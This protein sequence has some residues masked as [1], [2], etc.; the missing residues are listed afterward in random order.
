MHLNNLISHKI[1]EHRLF[2]QCGRIDMSLKTI[3]LCIQ[4]I[5][6]TNVIV[7]QTWC[8]KTT[9]QSLMREVLND[10]HSPHRIRVTQTLSNSPEFA[11]TFK[12]PVN[13]PMNPE[14]KCIIW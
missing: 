2:L 6:E 9:K 7:F 8:E 10:P 12:C 1:Y 3:L 11:R 4:K 5:H 13:S 14:N